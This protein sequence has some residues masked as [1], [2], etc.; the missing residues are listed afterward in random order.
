MKSRVNSDFKFLKQEFAAIACTTPL[1]SLYV[2]TRAG[3]VHMIDYR[4][5]IESNVLRAAAASSPIV[6]I[7]VDD[8]SR[9][10]YVRNAESKVCGNDCIHVSSNWL[11]CFP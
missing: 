5:R 4:T 2:G 6:Q 3:H 11:I 7:V 1:S 8:V 10:L 9:R